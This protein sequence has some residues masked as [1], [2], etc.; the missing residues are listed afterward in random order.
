MNTQSAEDAYKSVIAAAGATAP[1]WDYIDSRYISEVTNGK[2]TYTGSKQKLKGIIDSQNDAGG[3]PNNSNFKGGTAPT[4]TDK[5]GIPDTWESEHGLN[6]ND[7]KDGAIVSL[8]GDDYTNLELY[9]NELAGDTVAFNGTPI[10]YDPITGGNLVQSI[11]VKD[12]T[13]YNSWGIDTTLT[14]GDT[15]F[16]DRSADRCAVSELPSY[17]EGA[18]LVLT[19]CDAKNSNKD[20]AEL[21]FAQDCTLYVGL[22]SRVE[23]IPA[24]MSDFTKTDSAIKTT[25]DLSFELYAKSVKAG[26]VVKLGANGQSSYCMNYI[27]MASTAEPAASTLRGDINADG[28]FDVADVVLLQKWLLAVPD[29]HL[30]DWKAGDLYEDD[31]LDVFDL[32]LMKR[33]LLK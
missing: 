18:E 27:V 25:N 29:T 3:Y 4:D 15:L 1:Q 13:Y 22:D 32:C 2:F 20:Q 33:E 26:D 31:R 7:A 14:V 8:S 21:T 23:N 17:L 28:K 19:P 30:A 11:D 16:G 10:T 6:P 24:W 9:L 12:T 5:D